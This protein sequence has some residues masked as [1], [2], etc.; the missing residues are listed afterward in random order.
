MGQPGSEHPLCLYPEIS[1]TKADQA[2]DHHPEYSIGKTANMDEAEHKRLK[3]KG[4][5]CPAKN[6]F[7]GMHNDAP[8]QNL[9]GKR[10][11]KGE[12]QSRQNEDEG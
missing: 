3:D 8:K 12:G 7:Q 10:I 4:H 2:G 11:H 1:E 6:L 5:A 9:L